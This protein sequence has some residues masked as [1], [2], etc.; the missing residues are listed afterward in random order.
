MANDFS[1]DPNCVAVY[2]FE[3]GALTTDS[4]GANTLSSS[5]TPTAD[6][7]DYRE[8][9]AS[10]DLD[11]VGGDYYTC[12]DAALDAGFPLKNGTTNKT[13]S[14]CAWIQPHNA[15][16]SYHYVIW[17]KGGHNGTQ[18]TQITVFGA[19]TPSVNFTIAVD[20]GTVVSFLTTAKLTLGQWYHIGCVYDDATFNWRIRVW[21]DTAGSILQDITQNSD[22][23]PLCDGDILGIGVESIAILTSRNW[24]GRLD[25]VVTFNRALTADEIDLIRAGMY[26]SW[27][28]AGTIAGQ[29][30]VTGALTVIDWTPLTYPG[31]WPVPE[32]LR[33]E[34]RIH[35]PANGPEQRM[36]WAKYPRQSFALPVLT[37]TAAETAALEAKVHKYAKRSWAVPV[38]GEQIVH[39][40]PIAA[41]AGSVACDTRYAD[42]R[43]SSWALLWQRAH[44]EMIQIATV[45]DDGLTLSRNVQ[46]GFAGATRICPIRR[47]VLI[48]AIRQSQYVGGGA[49]F[50]LEYDVVNNQLVSGHVAALE[51]DGYEVLTV[52]SLCDASWMKQMDAATEILDTGFGALAVSRGT[53][54]NVVLRPHVWLPTT[55]Q[56]CWELR[57]FLHAL[58]GMQKTLLVPTFREDI[59]VTRAVGAGDTSLYVEYRGFASNYGA[60]ALRQYLAF[61]PVGADLIV[62]KVTAI[63]AVSSTEERIDLNAAPGAIFP[64]GAY[65]CWVDR[66]RLASDTVPLE[67]LGVGKLRCQVHWQLVEA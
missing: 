36:A 51:Y 31:L 7:G 56:A 62:R 26:G 2:R 16:S 46:A 45:A 18:Q 22:A 23:N 5:G 17:S 28:L 39:T 61:R 1:G 53:D 10:V 52:P 32:R 59:R 9:A 47:A 21:D 54:F 19:T 33:W 64:M 8:G 50:D 38:W 27:P 25:E 24:D 4:K 30:S 13:F 67:W 11:Y 34:T 3:D 63:T 65:L 49:I 41:G 40:A 66:C 6:T 60:N 58:V 37:R 14:V 44:Q 55:K 15:S 42:F 20:G 48:S 29:S 35:T 43:A 12:A 57:Q